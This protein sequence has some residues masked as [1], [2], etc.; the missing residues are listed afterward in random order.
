MSKKQQI[1]TNKVKGMPKKPV[2]QEHHISYEPEETVLIYKGEHYILT[3][4]QWRKYISKGLIKSLKQFIKDYQHL[5]VPLKKPKKKKTS[6]KKTSTKRKKSTK[7]KSTT[8]KARRKRGT[9]R[10]IQKSGEKRRK[11]KER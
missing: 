10:S 2:I 7:K 1:I 4:L 8:T 3:L 6:R 9:K 11:S 5:A